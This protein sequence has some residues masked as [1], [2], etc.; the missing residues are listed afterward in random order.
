MFESIT[1]VFWW[2][3]VTVV[4]R[5]LF[6]GTFYFLEIYAKITTEKWCVPQLYG[7]GEGGWHKTFQE[8]IIFEHRWYAT[9]LFKNVNCIDSLS[10]FSRAI[11]I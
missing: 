5:L 6:L 9:F 4:K 3:S 1:A 7:K 11:K 2:Y 8:L 10:T